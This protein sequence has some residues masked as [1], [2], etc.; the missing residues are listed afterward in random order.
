MQRKKRRAKAVLKVFNKYT[1]FENTDVP[2]RAGLKELSSADLE[3]PAPEEN[4]CAE[5]DTPCDENT[6]NVTETS[7]SADNSGKCAPDTVL[8][9]EYRACAREFEKKLKDCDE[10]KK[11]R[12]RKRLF[13]NVHGIR[14]IK[15]KK[16]DSVLDN[17]P[18]AEV[19]G[20]ISYKK[21]RHP[22]EK[23]TELKCGR[24]SW[25]VVSAPEPGTTIHGYIPAENGKLFGIYER[26][27]L[28]D[29]L[30]PFVFVGT[31]VIALWFCYTAG[32]RELGL[33]P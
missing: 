4:V 15:S 26:L 31:L 29:R 22:G 17:V 21:R 32:C 5:N 3:A 6:E 8:L 27:D 1:V 11:R 12:R 14:I 30:F 24:S 25:D 13:K 18:E 16:L 20:Y 28:F 9:P 10:F 7:G 23:I 33:T 19:I 2:A